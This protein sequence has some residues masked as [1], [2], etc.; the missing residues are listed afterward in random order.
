[1]KTSTKYINLDYEEWVE[2]TKANYFFLHAD[3]IRFE[4]KIREIETNIV[5]GTDQFQL[6]LDAAYRI[7]SD[8]QERVN[9]D[10]I[11]C[12]SN[13]NEW[14]VIGQSNYQGGN[15]R[16]NRDN[17]S[18]IPEGANIVLGSDRKVYT[19]QCKRCNEWFHYANR[20]PEVEN[21][22]ISSKV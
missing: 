19:I 8:T 1:M 21:G 3:K 4:D 9:Q 16:S 13:T 22:E 7:L 15:R 14:R 5:L 20:C 17:V 2:A 12:G 18:T 10:R 6:T 11:R